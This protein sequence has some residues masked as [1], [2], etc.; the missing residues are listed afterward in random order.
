MD[1]EHLDPGAGWP[2]GTS[3]SSA[4]PPE[5]VSGSW[6]PVL[7]PSGE[8][9]HVDAVSSSDAAAARMIELEHERRRIEAELA[10]LVDSVHRSGVYGDDGHR[11]VNGWVRTHSRCSDAEVT[12]RRRVGRLAHAD[13]RFADAIE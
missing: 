3:E 6:A 11:S 12:D 7:D 8:D 2:P 5:N 4:S 13:D 1:R 9:V 10:V